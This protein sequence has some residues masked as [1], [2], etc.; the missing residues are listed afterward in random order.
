[1]FDLF[2]TN[3]KIVVVT[4]NKGMALYNLVIFLSRF[5]D[6]DNKLFLVKP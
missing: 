3:P 4:E 6:F 5:N 2:F 1:M